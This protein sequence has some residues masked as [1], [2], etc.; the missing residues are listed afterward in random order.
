MAVT[1]ARA[2]KEQSASL[3]LPAGWRTSDISWR[4]SMWG[5]S[6]AAALS[7]SDLSDE[8]K[9]KFGLPKDRLAFRQ[10]VT[11]SAA[12]KLAGV[13]AHDVILGFAGRDWPMTARQ[14]NAF[15]RLNYAVGDTVTVNLLRDGKRLA[16]PMTLP[17]KQ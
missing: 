16:L 15:V 1:W 4:P 12:A 8:E 9:E 3:N 5:L 14:F 13:R 17:E 11:V 2:G 7:G 6:P 10:S